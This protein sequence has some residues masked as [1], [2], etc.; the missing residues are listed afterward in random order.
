MNSNPSNENN[1]DLLE[2]KVHPHLV[3]AVQKTVDRNGKIRVIPSTLVNMYDKP[4]TPEF[5]KEMTFEK[6]LESIYDRIAAIGLFSSRFVNVDE[7]TRINYTE[8]SENI[9]SAQIEGCETIDIFYPHD[10]ISYYISNEWLF[11]CFQTQFYVEKQLFSHQHLNLPSVINIR[12]SSGD[13]QKAVIKDTDFIRLRKGSRDDS[14]EVYIKVHFS[15]E[16]PNETVV[17]NCV[18]TKTIYLKDIMELN[19]EFSKLK[20]T[21]PKDILSNI[22]LDNPLKEKVVS[23][24]K[25]EY[26]RWILEELF[27]KLEK[28]DRVEIVSEE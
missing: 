20:V 9:I 6:A 1:N 7:F 25:S 16:D 11:Q 26:E 10:R 22:V 5:A 14:N 4:C 27:P 23:Y 12:R 24:I 3:G 18:Y 21:K 19:P 13:I 28:I 8:D 2:V 15:I 17:D